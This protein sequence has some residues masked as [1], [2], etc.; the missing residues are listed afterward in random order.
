M[1]NS[2]ELNQGVAGFTARFGVA[3]IEITP[4]VGIYFRN[5]G[6][7]TFETAESIHRSLYLTSLTISSLEE[8]NEEPPLILVSGDLSW[9]KSAQLFEEMQARLIKELGIP[10]ENF[11]FSLTHTHAAPPLQRAT[12]ELPGGELLNDFL[13]QV[14]LSTLEVINT[15][16][17]S[18]QPG[19]LDWHYGACRLATVRDLP[20]TEKSESF[21]C[22]FNPNEIADD[23]LLV[24]RVSS[25]TG[26]SLATLI[27]YACHPTT[28]AWENRAIS[29]DYIGAMQEVVEEATGSL[30]LFLQG[31]SGELSPREQYT[32]DLDVVDRH[33]RQLGHAVLAA[34]ADMHPPSSR[35]Q[36]DHVEPSG[37]PL[38]VWKYAP[39]VPE[40]NKQAMKQDLPLPLKKWPTAD[41]LAEQA[42]ETKD[43]FQ[44]ERLYRQ[45]E[46]RLYLGDQEE[47]SLPV[48]YWKLGEA[49]LMG[50][51]AESYSVLQQELRR[52]FPDRHVVCVNL[53]NGSIGYLAPESMYDRD[54]YQV[55]QSP[56]DR[57][58]LERLIDGAI[59]SVT[60]I[61]QS[62]VQV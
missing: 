59:D 43:S 24:G 55:W 6:A 11:W 7:A 18:T 28:L 38:A 56:F 14:E 37:A 41:E 53:L 16:M 12:E 48:W 26:E 44:R 60:S 3:R 27:N 5:W 39:L 47:W 49:I 57:G 33:G 51:M 8:Q 25:L 13:N 1:K 32:A 2:A 15:A 30:S 36:F 46:I 9:W 29:P 61:T 20:D 50:T 23:T 54:I 22:G 21:N 34:L 35:F 17:A 19:V 31:A 40:N 58:A 4:P 10:I 62:D 45:R 52:R 42:E